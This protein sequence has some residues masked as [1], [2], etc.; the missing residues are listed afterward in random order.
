LKRKSHKT[1]QELHSLNIWSRCRYRSLINETAGKT[2]TE[3]LNLTKS[4]L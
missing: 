3:S 2:Q 1:I 4:V